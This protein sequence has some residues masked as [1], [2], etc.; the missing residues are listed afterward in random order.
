MG[1][2]GPTRRREAL[3]ATSVPFLRPPITE[4]EL[5]GGDHFRS[6]ATEGTTSSRGRRLSRP[7]GSRGLLGSLAAFVLG[8]DPP[9]P[10][11]PRRI[12]SRGLAADLELVQVFPAA[13]GSPFLV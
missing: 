12:F 7:G 11:E 9:P 3:R 10:G 1:T 2:R 5:R 13:W 4:C 8:I 6:S